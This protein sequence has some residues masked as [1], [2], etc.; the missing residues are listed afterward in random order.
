VQPMVLSE[1]S[2]RGG[3]LTRGC[4]FLARY[5][6]AAP[7]STMGRRLYREPPRGM[8]KLATFHQ[9]IRNLLDAN[10]PLD[11][12]GRL[13]PLQLRLTPGAFYLWRD[14]HDEIERQL[15]PLG[16]Y[17]TVR[18]FA[19]KSAEN[20]ARIAGCLHVFE[21]VQGAISHENMQRATTL[22]RW[23]LREALRVMDVLDEP[24]AWMDARLLDS[25]LAK[26][27]YSPVPDVLHLGPGP[28]RNKARRDAAIEVLADL[29]RARIECG[30]GRKTLVRNPELGRAA[31]ATPATSAT[32]EGD[33]AG[34]VAEFATVAVA[35][36]KILGIERGEL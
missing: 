4:G 12:Q 3:G 10:L 25:W 36:D 34:N 13:R 22:A 18:D 27:G 14:Y 16:D 19:A 24:Q 2:Q 30:G 26:E 31:T 35:G 32:D 5:L 17:E 20:A 1:L 11:D 23:Y 9:R 7:V 33:D 29:G 28:L 21:G 15:N 8:P 6:M